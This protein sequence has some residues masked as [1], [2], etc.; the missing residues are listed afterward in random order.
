M[1]SVQAGRLETRRSCYGQGEEVVTGSR[2][3]LVA[4]CEM[5]YDRPGV[6]WSACPNC[7]LFFP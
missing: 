5:V 1:R 3:R 2:G 4:C 6:I 7:R